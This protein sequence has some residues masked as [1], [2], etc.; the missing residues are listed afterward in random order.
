LY[1]AKNAFYVTNSSKRIKIKNKKLYNA[2]LIYT[3]MKK[4]LLE[5]KKITYIKENK[6]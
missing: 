1:E 3:K 4:Y 2:V 5:L 6:N